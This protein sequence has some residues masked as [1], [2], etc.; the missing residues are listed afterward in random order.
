MNKT[1]ARID[2]L[3]TE[4]ENES[5]SLSELLEIQEAFEL[6]NPAT[7]RDL[8]ENASAGDMLDEVEE[9]LTKEGSIS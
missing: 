6:L 7:L 9:Y 5:I 3:R 2:Y 8:P 1:K 4:L